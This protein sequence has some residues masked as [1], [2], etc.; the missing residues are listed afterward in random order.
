MDWQYCVNYISCV[1]YL[2]LFVTLYIDSHF[3]SGLLIVFTHG[4]GSAIDTM[5][6]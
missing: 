6:G 1:S 4:K 2:T 3:C 5:A